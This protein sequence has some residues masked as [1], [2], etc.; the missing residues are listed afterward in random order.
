MGETSIKVLAVN[1]PA[2]H[3]YNLLERYE[4]GLVLTGTEVKS[5]RE[6]KVQLKD[7]YAEIRGNEAWLVN[8]HISHYSHGNIMNH[9]PVRDRK[10]LL[11]ASEIHKLLGKTRERG[12]TLIPTRV[13]LK[14]G[15]IKC[16]LAL[17]KAK[18]LHDKRETERRREV[19]AEARTAMR[20]GRER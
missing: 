19:E 1:R 12:F 17:A 9:H 5:A 7:A 18:K 8:A 2:G 3:N 16:E 20:R 6:G 13:Y 14:S 11:H 10:L 4:A 15:R